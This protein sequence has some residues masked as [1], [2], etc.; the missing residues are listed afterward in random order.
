MLL[1]GRFSGSTGSHGHNGDSLDCGDRE[2]VAK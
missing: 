2:G 1:D